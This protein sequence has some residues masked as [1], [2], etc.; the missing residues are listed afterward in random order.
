MS[1]TLIR[2]L[3][4]NL[5]D[6]GFT[7]EAAAKIICERIPGA[8]TNAKGFSSFRWQKRK[9]GHEAMTST[10]AKKLTTGLPVVAAVRPAMPA[11]NPATNFFAKVQ[12]WIGMFA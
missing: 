10:Q 11:S 4:F 8:K 9:A 6:A 3:A 5:I 2:E 7:N 12:S 1:T